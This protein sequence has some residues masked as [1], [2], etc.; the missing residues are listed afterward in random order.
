MA[1]QPPASHGPGGRRPRGL[2]R[3]RPLSIPGARRET[4]LV[5]ALLAGSG[6]AALLVLRAT[7][8]EPVEGGRAREARRPGSI[9]PDRI[10]YADL[11]RGKVTELGGGRIEVLYDFEPVPKIEGRGLTDVDL[12]PQLEDWNLSLADSRTRTGVVRG[13]GRLVGEAR[14]RLAFAGPVEVSLQLE[15]VS[16]AAAIQLAT[17]R[18]GEGCE[19]LID[20]ASG[21]GRLR[22][23]LGE[24][25]R[26]IEWDSLELFSGGPLFGL[27]LGLS[28]TLSDEE[29]RVELAGRWSARA[30]VPPGMARREGNIAL[31][32]PGGRVLWDDVR[33]RGEM[34][35]EWLEDRL[36]AALALL[37][38]DEFE[39]DDSWTYS[40]ELL[41]DGT[42]QSRT[43]CPEND[44]DWV[45]VVAPGSGGAV[46][47]ETV[48]LHFGV[49][50]T[51]D[52]FEADGR[53]PIEPL[54]TGRDSEAQEP[55][56]AAALVAVDGRRAFYVRISE[57]E[58]RRGTYRL[59]ARPVDHLPT[60]SRGD[61]AW[62]ARRP[63]PARPAPR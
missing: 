54:P 7:A 14:T 33:I 29:L 44:A 24:E 18:S 58:G 6:G 48:G 47:V 40:R 46:L 22:S 19:V 63:T 26:E 37:G 28:A 53:T 3:A 30:R 12:Y 11:I 42:E 4:L 31:R 17:N 51:L 13:E 27:R 59:R 5:L 32:S 20:G 61:G 25:L 10:P 55:G 39:P 41:A 56:S 35:R 2:A 9:L 1:D 45:S 15:I 16:G 57:A 52:I 49:R 60:A 43:L 50:T 21:L 38:E 62:P 23:R 34:S 8:R 36:H